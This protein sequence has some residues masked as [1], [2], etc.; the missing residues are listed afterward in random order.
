MQAFHDYTAGLREQHAS[1][2][3]RR[4]R[5]GEFKDRAEKMAY[6]SRFE[7]VLAEEEASW[8]RLQ[9]SLVAGA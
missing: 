7:A 8:R 3:A 9:V 5:A 6:V 1:E 4:V 2:F